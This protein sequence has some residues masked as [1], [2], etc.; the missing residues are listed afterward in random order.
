MT[1][2]NEEDLRRAEYEFI[3][4]HGYGVAHYSEYDDK[5]Q[6]EIIIIRNTSDNYT[7]SHAVN[8][9]VF[10]RE[11]VPCM[12][13]L[14]LEPVLNYRV[15][16]Q[17]VHPILNRYPYT[18]DDGRAGVSVWLHSTYNDNSNRYTATLYD[19]HTLR[20]LTIDSIRF[21]VVNFPDV[22][23]R[24]IAYFKPEDLMTRA[25][26]RSRLSVDFGSFRLE[27]DALIQKNFYT[28]T[29]HTGNQLT[30]HGYLAKKNSA[31]IEFEELQDLRT[32]LYF[33][34]SLLAGRWSPLVL[35]DVFRRQNPL[36]VL[37]PPEESATSSPA[38]QWAVVCALESA[39]FDSNLNTIA[40]KIYE[41][42]STDK[43]PAVISIM[44]RWYIECIASNASFESCLLSAVAVIETVYKRQTTR[45]ISDDL[46]FEKKQENYPKVYELFDQLKI[47]HRIPHLW[48][49]V[50]TFYEAFVTIAPEKHKGSV[51]PLIKKIRNKIYHH[52]IDDIQQIYATAVSTRYRIILMAQQLAEETLLRH[53]GFTGEL[54]KREG[55]EAKFYV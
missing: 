24:V 23:N 26:G 10:Y 8:G 29:S 40:T 28:Q 7:L 21:H 41:I 1:D 54:A 16:F 47:E 17:S 15:I 6:D 43:K 33:F 39:N 36:G 20:S 48:G 22:A 12:F 49:D 44:L 38:F 31:L 51:I 4:K 2:F 5:S 42:V 35:L 9:H 32:A 13:H 30:H 45:E 53:L 18:L 55:L 27:L 37:H 25:F 14:V 46:K 52:D 19:S 50:K 34:L 3:A 11:I